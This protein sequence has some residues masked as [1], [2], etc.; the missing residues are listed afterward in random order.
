MPARGIFHGAEECTRR[1][2]TS[3]QEN[4]ETDKDDDEAGKY[5]GN[6]KPRLASD[7]LVVLGRW[8]GGA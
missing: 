4:I 1:A 2:F 8:V 6:R 3:P 5:Q 7:P